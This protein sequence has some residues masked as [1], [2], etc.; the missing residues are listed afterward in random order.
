MQQVMEMKPEDSSDDDEEDE[1]TKP[2][3]PKVSENKVAQDEGKTNDESK[4]D[5]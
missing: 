5:Q 2:S 4:K 3:P 1:I